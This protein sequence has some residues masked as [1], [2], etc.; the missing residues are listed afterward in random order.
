MSE[1]QPII[2][3][4]PGGYQQGP[5]VMVQPEFGSVQG[6]I[7]I[8]MTGNRDW[9]SGIC[10]CMQDATN[11]VMVAFCAPC[12]QC[13]IAT[14]MGEN[15]CVP[16]CVPG[17]MIALRQ[18][19]RTLGGIQGTLCGDCLVFAVC[20]QCALCQMKREMDIMGIV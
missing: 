18:R 17:A 1:K 15:V 13:Q 9:S 14:R 19:L 8:P 3:S 2:S 20:G 10:D 4:Q 16:F 11:C 5:V 12:V 6:K 7:I